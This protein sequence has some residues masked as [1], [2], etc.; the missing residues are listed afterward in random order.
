VW[1]DLKTKPGWKGHLE[2]VLPP[3]LEGIPGTPPLRPKDRLQSIIQEF[4]TEQYSW[5]DLKNLFGLW[6]ESINVIPEKDRLLILIEEDDTVVE[7]KNDLDAFGLYN[8][9][10][11]MPE[12]NDSN[13][14]SYLRFTSAEPNDDNGIDLTFSSQSAE[15][16]TIHLHSESAFDWSQKVKEKYALQKE[17][18]GVKGVGKIARTRVNIRAAARREA[19]EISR[20]GDVQRTKAV[21]KKLDELNKAINKL[22]QQ[23]GQGLI[24]KT[25]YRKYLKKL[26]KM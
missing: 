12:N 16:Y 14:A 22:E 24:T 11:S 5:W 23:Y 9:Y 20:P 18:I 15:G 21:V 19:E 4:S 6:T 17:A 3:Y 26:Y 10:R 13:T 2:V 8:A 25:E 7:I 1:K